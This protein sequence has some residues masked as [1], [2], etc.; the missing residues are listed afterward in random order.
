MSELYIPVER[1][2]RNPINGRFLKGIAP[3]NKGKTMKYHSLK[4]KRRSL[5][6]L[7]KGRGSWHKTGA[8]L[9]RKS[10]VAIKDGKLCGVFPSIQDAGKAT[11]V[12]P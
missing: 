5:K 6:N 3:H 9:N 1:P 12:N 4:T 8:G 2:T 7:A 10:V 11:G